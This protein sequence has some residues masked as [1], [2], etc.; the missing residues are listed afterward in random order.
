MGQILQ[1]ARTKPFPASVTIFAVTSKLNQKDTYAAKQPLLDVT[2]RVQKSKG[3]YC[4]ICHKSKEKCG[5]KLQELN[6]IILFCK[7][8]ICSRIKHS[9]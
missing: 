9:A 4:K 5:Q 2:G 7:M 8:S 1:T 6:P 3:S